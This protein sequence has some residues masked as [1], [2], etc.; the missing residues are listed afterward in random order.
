MNKE[1]KVANGVKNGVNDKWEP[2]NLCKIGT[3]HNFV[4]NPILLPCTYYQGLSGCVICCF[5]NPE[6]LDFTRE[7]YN[8][9]FIFAH[10]VTSCV[11]G[12]K[13]VL[14][15][16]NWGKMWGIKLSTQC[17]EELG[18]FFTIFSS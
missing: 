9:G 4:K 15:G 3:F 8:Y 10:Y 5:K 17:R 14:W 12:V 7:I 13:S 1:I 16:K 18:A 11:S 2:G 6:S